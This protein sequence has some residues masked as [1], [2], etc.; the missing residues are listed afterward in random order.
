MSEKG[1]IQEMWKSSKT[2]AQDLMISIATWVADTDFQ[3]LLSSITD[4]VNLDNWQA[5]WSP[6]MIAALLALTVIVIAARTS[7]MTHS[8][9][10][11]AST[12]AQE[13]IPAESGRLLRWIE[14]GREQRIVLEARNAQLQS[15]NVT[16][17]DMIATHK[18]TAAKLGQQQ[19]MLQNQNTRLDKEINKAKNKF[20]TEQARCNK[21]QAQIQAAAQRDNHHRQALA[22]AHQHHATLS[23]TVTKAQTERDG[24]YQ[25][26]VD[27][28]YKY[29]A[30][31]EPAT[32]SALRILSNAQQN[33]DVAMP[34]VMVLVDGD[35]YSFN[36]NHYTQK[37]TKSGASAAHA[38]KTEVQQYLLQ[39]R[40]VAP[41]QS[42]IVT[43]VLHNMT[44]RFRTP[45]KDEGI[46]IFPQT[47]EFVL[48]FTESMP[49]FDYVDCGRGK[50]RSA[51]TMVHSVQNY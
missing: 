29:E 36:S 8:G 23:A 41:L 24:W 37:N 12:S 47:P 32:D 5:V 44:E 27:L 18:T 35:A 13:A 25:Q 21:L 48:T 39:N 43:R 6:V 17:K 14:F 49:L 20:H 51:T 50:E 46:T 7:W 31:Q 9:A 4:C 22:T 28:K 26:Y 42:K 34:F 38:I 15:E 30:V 16:L 33:L 45:K 2:G 3:A 10:H 19:A 40:D 11:R 1:A